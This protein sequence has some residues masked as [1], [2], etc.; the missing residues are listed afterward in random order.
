MNALAIVPAAGKA[1]R[2][3]GGKLVADIDGEPLLNRTLRSL[4]D[5]GVEKLVVI[6]APGTT[7]ATVHL[8]SDPRV[9]RVVNPNPERGMFSSILIGLAAE[10]G[11]PI[12]VLPGDMPFVKAETVTAVLNEATRTGRIVSPRFGGRH[13]HPVAFPG[14]LKAEI[15]KADVTWTLAA[16]LQVHDAQRT[17]IDVSDPGVHRDVDARGD[18]ASIKFPKGKT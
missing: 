5:G 14:T 2:F 11:D 10:E 18:L 4:I 8:L 9:R 15:L 7:F 17:S 1:E 16:V 12:L 6:L 3:G 13:G